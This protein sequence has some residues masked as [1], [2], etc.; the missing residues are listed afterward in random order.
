LSVV[1]GAIPPGTSNKL[2]A[3]NGVLMRLGLFVVPALDTGGTTVQAQAERTI[4]DAELRIQ[5]IGWHWNTRIV[6]MPPIEATS[7]ITSGRVPNP[8]GPLLE[9]DTAGMTKAA[10]IEISM[11][12][13]G[14]LFLLP[15]MREQFDSPLTVEIIERLPFGSIPGLFMAWIVAEAA[16]E[17]GRRHVP[18]R[19]RDE[20]R[21]AERQ[22]ARVA[23][24]RQELRLA[25]VNLLSGTEHMAVLGRSRT[26]RWSFYT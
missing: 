9:V 15:E 21:V 1:F 10:G 12:S 19:H 8:R 18:D 11:D 22:Q 16:F 4:D 20:E 25:D 17:F 23:A 26:P 6:E 5:R 14:K 13:S 2:D 7:F 3:V 24:M